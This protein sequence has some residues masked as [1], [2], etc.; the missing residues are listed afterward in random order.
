[1]GGRQRQN[2]DI[3]LTT[4]QMMLLAIWKLP[5]LL[6]LLSCHAGRV[7]AAT[8]DHNGVFKMPGSGTKMIFDAGTVDETCVG[9]DTFRFIEERLRKL[10]GMTM[11]AFLRSK[12]RY[13]FGWC[14]RTALGLC[15][16]FMVVSHC[17]YIKSAPH[18]RLTRA[19]YLFKE[20]ASA[21]SFV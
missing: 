15:C 7:R 20:R 11:G 3:A 18:Q 19:L 5:L 17:S 12:S 1:M 13:G 8:L 21:A 6:L 4:S 2:K 16:F 9:A 14:W 10:E